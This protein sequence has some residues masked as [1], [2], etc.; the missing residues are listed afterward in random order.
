MLLV[1]LPN[2]NERVLLLNYFAKKCGLLGEGSTEASE[3]LLLKLKEGMSGAEIENLC[4][5]AT[6]DLHRKLM[7]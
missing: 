7:Q 6:L 3:E 2:A 1:P 5:E 4:R